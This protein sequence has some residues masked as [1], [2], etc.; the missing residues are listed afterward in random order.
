M[1]HYPSLN[2]AFALAFA[3]DGGGWAGLVGGVVRWDR[4]GRTT[5]HFTTADGLGGDF[6]P[7]LAI[8][9]DGVLWAATSG[10]VSRFDGRAWTTLTETDGSG[11]G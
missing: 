9:P 3:P 10:G 2:N 7:D 11:N 5:H 4:Y 8:G 6:V 1:K